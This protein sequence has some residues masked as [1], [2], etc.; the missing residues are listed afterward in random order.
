MSTPLPVSA[1]NAVSRTVC[2]RPST[3]SVIDGSVSAANASRIVSPR[4]SSVSRATLETFVPIV[5]RPRRTAARGHGIAN[6]SPGPHDLR[7]AVHD[8]VAL[9][10][11][12][13][14][15][16][17]HRGDLERHERLLRGRDLQHDGLGPDR[18]RRTAAELGRPRGLQTDLM[19][20]AVPTAEQER[21][22]HR[23][24]ESL[25]LRPDRDEDRPSA[26]A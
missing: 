18:L 9:Q 4:H 2:R 1:S 8:E 17:L 7:L 11:V 12:P 13:A 19:G 23:G 25:E 24:R 15:G 16:H 26:R 21:A 3:V 5:T 20:Q 6:R 14:R 10:P 22:L